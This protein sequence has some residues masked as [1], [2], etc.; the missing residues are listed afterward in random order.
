MNAITVDGDTSTN[1]T[2]LLLASGAAGNAPP[3][4]GSP[5]HRRLARAVTEVLGEI[6]RLVVL[7]GEGVAG[8]VVRG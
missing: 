4:A 1:D 8:D 7:D 3:A 6:A 5:D 2:T